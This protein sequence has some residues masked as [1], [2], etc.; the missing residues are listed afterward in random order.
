MRQSLMQATSRVS[1]HMANK[2]EREA[3]D[4]L[5][6][7]QPGPVALVSSRFRSTDNI[8]TAAWL[9]PLSFDPP[10]VGVAIHSGR[11]THELVTGSEFF[12]LNIP[13]ADLLVAV[14]RCGMTTGRDGD[15]FEAAGLTPTDAQAIEAP[16]IEECVAHIEC[17]VVGRYTIGDHDLFVGRPLAVSADAEAF[18]GRWLVETDAGQV[19]HH[20]RADYYAALSRPY[21]AQLEPDNE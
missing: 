10:L 1:S 19:L 11:L 15:K 16:L 20:L 17:G 8:M 2:T 9:A 4:A 5:R 6:V 14:H 7:L 12:A 13:T 3:I 18:N 21:R